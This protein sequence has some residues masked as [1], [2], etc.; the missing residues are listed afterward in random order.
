MLV[1]WGLW[2][3]MRKYRAS[4][5]TV[6]RCYPPSCPKSSKHMRTRCICMFVVSIWELLVHCSLRGAVALDPL[7]PVRCGLHAH[8][9]V[10]SGW[11]TSTGFRPS[12]VLVLEQLQHLLGSLLC[13]LASSGSKNGGPLKKSNIEL[14]PP[15]TYTHR[16]QYFWSLFWL[17]LTH[18]LPIPVR[19]RWNPGF[20]SLPHWGNPVLQR[21]PVWHDPQLGQ[22]VILDARLVQWKLKMHVGTMQNCGCLS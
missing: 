5:Q 7:S 9:D 4:A 20:N 17:F 12:L 10:L 6:S 13:R 15:H 14:F 22:W 8:V 18:W 1:C 2:S 11:V 19:L 3:A 16:N 21:R